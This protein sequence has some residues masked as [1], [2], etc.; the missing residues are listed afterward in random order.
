MK[1]F[2]IL[3]IHLTSVLLL[4][5]CNFFPEPGSL[6]QAPKQIY[7][8]ASDD[9]HR[10]V[11][12]KK[13]LPGNTS[14]SVP[15]EP[16]GMDS[17]IQADFNND[18]INEAVA[19]YKSKSTANQAGAIILQKKLNEWKPLTTFSGIG[20]EISW[21]SATDITGDGI[22][23]LL[24]GWKIGVTAGNVLDIYQWKD[25]QFSKLQQ[26]NFHEIELISAKNSYRLALWKR[27]FEDVYQV[28]V[29]KWNKNALVSDKELY[30]SYFAKVS[31][32]YQQRTE[33]VPDAA[34]YWYY[35]AESLQKA[36]QYEPALQAVNQ[37]ME[38]KL[39]AAEYDDFIKIKDEI[40]NQIARKKNEDVQYYIPNG[41][42]TMNFPRSLA[43][44]ILIESQEG[45]DMEY[46][47]HVWIT[48]GGE[49]RKLFSIE[50][51][52]KEFLP[53]DQFV[54]TLLESEHLIYTVS[55]IAENQVPDNGNALNALYNMALPHVKDIISSIRLGPYYDKH[56]SVE[57]EL[58]IEKVVDA[59]QKFIHVSMGGNMKSGIIESFLYEDLDYRYLGADINTKEKLVNY[60]SDS[61]TKDAIQT[62]MKDSRIIEQNGLLAQPNADGGSLLS[63]KN[64]TVINVKDSGSEI[65]YD[66]RVPLG[67]S[68]AFEVVHVVFRK[69]EEGWRISSSPIAL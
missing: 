44:H 68:L 19:F 15:N 48:E 32:Y 23:E 62:F 65:Q 33:A 30:P 54:Q 60:L 51:Q 18:G 36:E 20:Y 57:D 26:L 38:R 61:Y 2:R 37:G 67:N 47:V 10:Y 6:I 7:A 45:T 13:L 41:N 17:V 63:Y 25:H 4:G 34:Y 56:T 14:L 12:I 9:D 39:T 22:P 11:K 8:S 3:I 16:V 59:Y 35:L 28:D 27:L 43:S 50:I 31:G 69:T 40:E 53:E 64:A 49:K 46:I 24:L 66:L 52:A 42:I 29:L 1:R 58:L 55:Q 5:G 21:G